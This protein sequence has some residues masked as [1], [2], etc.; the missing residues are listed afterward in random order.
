MP[1]PELRYGVVVRVDGVVDH[2]GEAFG[3]PGL[4]V[5]DGSIVP[6][7]I[8]RDPTRTIAALA[9]RSAAIAFA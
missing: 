7:P 1:T 3:H 4:Y 8:G 5:V 6:V 9:E 2:K